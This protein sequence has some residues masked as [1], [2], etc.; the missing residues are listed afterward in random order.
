MA[1]IGW[2]AIKAT[3]F[4]SFHPKTNLFN[5]QQ[6]KWLFDGLVAHTVPKAH[7]QPQTATQLFGKREQKL[8]VTP[9]EKRLREDGLGNPVVSFMSIYSVESAPVVRVL[10]AP[11]RGHSS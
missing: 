4:F 1:K 9:R 8:E 11:L 6:G 10:Y 5:F 7:S 2:K 3:N